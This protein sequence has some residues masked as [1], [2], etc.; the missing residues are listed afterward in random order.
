MDE[1]G[2]GVQM[3]GSDEANARFPLELETEPAS[4]SQDGKTCF[5]KIHAPFETLAYKA[6][7]LRIKM[8]IRRNDTDKDPLQVLPRQTLNSHLP[9]SAGLDR[10]IELFSFCR[11]VSIGCCGRDGIRSS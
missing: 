8:P 6:E 7:E 1:V 3:L 9:T 11:A 5:V 10:K 4:Q 2:E